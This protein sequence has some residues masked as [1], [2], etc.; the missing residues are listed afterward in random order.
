LL[1]TDG[2]DNE[3]FAVSGAFETGSAYVAVTPGDA[4]KPVDHPNYLGQL[5]LRTG[6]IKSV[7]TTIQAKGMIFVP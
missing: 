6:V 5:D 3:V 1:V 7:V 4:N 2:V